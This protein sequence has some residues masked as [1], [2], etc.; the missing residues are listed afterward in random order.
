ME[1]S[2]YICIDLTHFFVFVSFCEEI[3]FFSERDKLNDNQR[4]ELLDTIDFTLVGEATLK[5][6]FETQVVPASFVA[7]GALSLCSKLKSEL[8]SAKNTVSKQEDELQRLR[9][10]RTITPTVTPSPK[11]ETE[12]G[13]SSK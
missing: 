4:Q 9:R 11:K 12:S 10:A 2:L 3:T 1:T 7:K 13:H 6:A 5:R 8:E